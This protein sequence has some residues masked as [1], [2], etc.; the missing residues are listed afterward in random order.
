MDGIWIGDAM[1]AYDGL[2]FQWPKRPAQPRGRRCREI[3][4]PNLPG[5]ALRDRDSMGLA[6]ERY[7]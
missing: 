4:L 1:H 2:K 6:E 7:P 3:R 5:S